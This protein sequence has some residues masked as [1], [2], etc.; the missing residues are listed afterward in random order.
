MVK[1]LAKPCIDI[2]KA[3]IISSD[4][5]K[6]LLHAVTK[7]DADLDLNSDFRSKSDRINNR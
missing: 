2:A 4:S 1:A 3:I 7:I 6:L 5:N